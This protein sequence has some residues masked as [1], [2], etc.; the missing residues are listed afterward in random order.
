MAY[1]GTN[2]KWH[3]HINSSHRLSDRSLLG[4]T[5]LCF[6]LLEGAIGGNAAATYHITHVVYL[7]AQWNEQRGSL[8][9][10]WFV[11]TRILGK[12]PLLWNSST[13]NFL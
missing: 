11:S 7:Q 8:V 9:E 4:L 1:D 6:W 5:G 2:A 12:T 3:W 13:E 10:N